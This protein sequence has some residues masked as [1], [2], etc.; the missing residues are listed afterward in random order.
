MKL[1]FVSIK[2]ENITMKEGS[3]SVLT[4]DSDEEAWIG[5]WN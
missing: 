4:D 1:R 3:M 2:Q 5:H